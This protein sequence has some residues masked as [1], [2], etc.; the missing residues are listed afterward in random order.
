MITTSTLWG[1]R[2]QLFASTCTSACYL[3]C[4]QLFKLEMPGYQY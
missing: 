4:S 1:P 2:G 3:Y